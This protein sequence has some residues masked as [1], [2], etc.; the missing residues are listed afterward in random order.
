MKLYVYLPVAVHPEPRKALLISYGVGS[1]AKALT[2]TESFEV[3]DAVD[4]SRDILEMSSVVF[5]DSGDNPLND[6]RVRVH[7]ED[8][9]YF[10]KTTDQ[11]YD[12][13]TGEPPPPNIAHVVNLYTREY[14]QLMRDRL[15][16]GGFVTYWLPL[17]SLG[18]GSAR[19][20]IR[21][22]LETF[23]DASLWHGRYEDL[24]LVGSR[25]AT[26]PVSTDR[27]R[28]QWEEPHLASELKTLGLEEP[29]QLGALFIG[30]AD[31]LRRLTRDDPPLVDDYPKRILPDAAP[32]TGSGA[33]YDAF[34]DVA[35]A[36][37]RFA[38]SDLIQRFWPGALLEETLPYFEFQGII[39]GL[40][41]PPTHPLDKGLADLQ[42]LLTGSTL[43]APTLWYMGSSGDVLAVLEALG[44]DE[45][46][47]PV[48]QYHIAAGLLSQ[49]RFEEA[50]EPL[51]N[52]E[53]NPALFAASRMLRIYLLCR[54][55]RLE[56][57]RGLARE[58]HPILQ[59]DSRVDG[60]WD[61]LSDTYGIDPR[62]AEEL[63]EALRG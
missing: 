5:P 11:S 31:Y 34:T 1:T 62:V 42:H 18:D 23:P 48:G 14:F 59:Q 54:L 7:I 25:N 39:N 46:D 15:N 52:A 43:T 44:P 12:L 60:W 3:I 50:L 21:A 28:Q 32:G 17:H 26:G 20:V 24:M 2:D 4:I 9:R 22:F 33:L 37:G 56:D 51:Q 19:A 36:R 29:E 8:G 40:I 41:G 58:T 53:G 6:P 63:E 55:N 35:A 10:L 45:S 49:R 57:A 38:E 27:F 13:I 47:D 61:F 16:D 30:D